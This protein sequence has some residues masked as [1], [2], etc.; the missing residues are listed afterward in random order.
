VKEVLEKRE[1]KKKHYFCLTTKL[2]I[3][4]TELKKH[5]KGVE[6]EIIVQV[7]VQVPEWGMPWASLH[8]I[9]KTMKTQQLEPPP[10]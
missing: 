4:E 6:N 3:H 9:V 10:A 5:D 8:S 1:L 2:C 7:T